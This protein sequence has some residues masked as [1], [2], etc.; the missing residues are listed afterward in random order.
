MASPL[1]HPTLGQIQG[2]LKDGVVQFLG[3]KY[4]SIKDRFAPS[5][6]FDSSDFQLTAFD[7][8]PLYGEGRRHSEWPIHGEIM[9]ARP[10]VQFTAHTHPFNAVIFSSILVMLAGANPLTVFWLV[11]KGAAGM[12]MLAALPAFEPNRA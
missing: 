11:L 9:Q 7:G 1:N 4:A 12:S 6:V 5:E 2:N 10:D 3:V 8:T